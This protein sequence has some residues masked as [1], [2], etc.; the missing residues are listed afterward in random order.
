LTT[1]GGYASGL[2]SIHDD[3]AYSEKTE[4]SRHLLVHLNKHDNCLA[5]DYQ[6]QASNTNNTSSNEGTRIAFT[7]LRWECQIKIM[8]ANGTNQTNISN[9]PDDFDFDPSRSPDGTKLAFSSSR[10]EMWRSTDDANR[11]HRP[12]KY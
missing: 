7:S 8:N 4:L 5:L 11:T 2:L 10:Y 6:A 9:I 12:V 3:I 1:Y